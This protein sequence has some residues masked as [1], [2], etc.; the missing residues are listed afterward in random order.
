M[1]DKY[2][3]SKRQPGQQRPGSTAF[4]EQG[5][6]D[7]GPRLK[8]AFIDNL[9]D[10]FHSSRE[11]CSV[12]LVLA[13]SGGQDSQAMLNL[14]SEIRSELPSEKLPFT[15]TVTVAH[16]NHALRPDSDEEERFVAG[17]A[18]DKGFLF[19]CQ[20]LSSPP[21]SNIE[22]WARE[23]RYRFF[24]SL[25]PGDNSLV[26]TAHHLDDQAETMLMRLLSGRFIGRLG[27]IKGRDLER[28]LLRPFLGF[29]RD[30]IESYVTLRNIP[31]YE[32]QSNSDTR[33]LRNY[34][35]H[36]LL[37]PAKDYFGPGVVRTLGR[38]VERLAE[39]EEFIDS[40]I[41]LLFERKLG[42][43]DY[44]NLPQS[45]R[46]R[47]LQG[48]AFRQ[49]GEEAF[50]VSQASWRSITEEMFGKKERNT[51]TCRVRGKPWRVIFGKDR[52]MF[53]ATQPDG[54]YYHREV[55]CPR[56]IRSLLVGGSEPFFWGSADGFMAGF[57]A[58]FAAD[59][60]NAG[61]SI[62]ARVWT[63]S[64]ADSASL[65]GKPPIFQAPDY[66]VPRSYQERRSSQIQENDREFFLVP[67]SSVSG[68]YCR[69]VV[70]G[71]RIDVFRRGHRRVAELF[72]EFAVPQPLRQGYPLVCLRG[73]SSDIKEAQELED[74]QKS[75]EG[76][77]RGSLE[78]IL[79]LPGIARSR[80]FPLPE[81][82][83]EVSTLLSSENSP[84]NFG[85]SLL[86][87]SSQFRV[88]SG[89][90]RVVR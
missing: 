76:V 17:R 41:E 46:W 20:R 23:Q 64:S 59:S 49:F 37:R 40:Q 56:M 62:F 52:P 77:E 10:Y 51:I 66:Q 63:G 35:R 60:D 82:T 54:G 80:L 75:V 3:S 61:F 27:R 7:I 1:E 73:E 13:C 74:T 26:V 50:S 78:Q 83:A 85:Y 16:V 84:L 21:S 58:D 81:S 79:W 55:A 34:V 15:I 33:Y 67:N 39:D 48:L 43:A 2:P 25:T 12:H 72:K 88:H 22:A 42:R 44:F 71:D 8:A 6:A 53:F 19:V 89:S 47:Y 86:E 18:G 29:T 14:L 69:A 31:T 45:L 28:R 11:I 70:P 24:S 90:T 65:G 4:P 32:D 36:Q 30:E 57:T 68:L 5:S 87:L 38:S 9:H